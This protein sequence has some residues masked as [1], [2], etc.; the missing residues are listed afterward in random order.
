MRVIWYQ[1]S[2]GASIV[3]ITEQGL[4]FNKAA[5]ESLGM[6]QY[7]RLGF[8]PEERYVVVQPT[9]S[10]EDAFPFA[11]RLRAGSVKVNNR[12]F[13]RQLRS[14]V[15]LDFSVTR[16]CLA[17]WNADEGVLIVDLNESID[18][19]DAGERGSKGEDS[20]R[21]NRNAERREQKKGK[22]VA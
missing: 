8:V 19:K 6:P 1:P 12:D 3:T 20:G 4:S 21:R 10:P 16:R 15:K 18:E 7:V 17:R 22:P 5:A 11:S 2:R 14:Y 13:I 9:D